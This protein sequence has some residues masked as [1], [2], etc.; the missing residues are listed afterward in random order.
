MANSNSYAMIRCAGLEK[1]IVDLETA[2]KLWIES[3]SR[4]LCPD[5]GSIHGPAC[6]GMRDDH[7]WVLFEIRF[8][9]GSL[10]QK[11]HFWHIDM[12]LMRAGEDVW[13]G[14]RNA[15]PVFESG[16]CDSP[17]DAALKVKRQ[18]KC[19]I[20]RHKDEEARKQD[21]REIRKQVPWNCG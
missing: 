13:P 18:I 9:V 10:R 12:H 8:I 15:E 21:L 1:L 3:A 19:A 20:K 7:P 16:E 17:K 2:G 4:A 6:E 11:P 14:D 5:C